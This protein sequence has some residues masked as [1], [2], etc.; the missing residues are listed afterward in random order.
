LNIIMEFKS[1]CIFFYK[2]LI[3]TYLIKMDQTTIDAAQKLNNEGVQLF[4]EEKYTD[5]IEKFKQA[6]AI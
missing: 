6:I 3:K 2:K 5:A 1:E 4:T